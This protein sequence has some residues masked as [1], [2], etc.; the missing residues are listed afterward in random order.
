MIIGLVAVGVILV[1]LPLAAWWL[2]GRAF[3]NRRRPTTDVDLYRQIVRRH[4]LHPA[5]AP[6]VEAAVTWGRRLDDPRLRA[7]AVDWARSLQEL[8]AER[9]ERHPR[10]RRVLLVLA[11]LYVGG[12]VAFAVWRVVHGD[13]DNL[14]R[15]VAYGLTFVVV[16]FLMVRGPRRAIERNSDPPER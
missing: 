1:G 13:W 4:R 15:L 16:T 8:A 5:E 7:A 10:R 6:R 12:V 9:R 3:W 14:I 11:P 2:G